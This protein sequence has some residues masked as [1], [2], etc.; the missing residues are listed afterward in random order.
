[1]PSTADHAQTI[2]P[3]FFEERERRGES[4]ERRER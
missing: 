2:I 3:S 1:M 4:L